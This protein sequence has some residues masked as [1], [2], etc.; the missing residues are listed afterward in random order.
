M[1]VE[2]WNQVPESTEPRYDPTR[3]V[4]S[5]QVQL[6]PGKEYVF[7]VNEE[8]HLGFRSEEGIPLAP[9]LVRFQTRPADKG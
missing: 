7:S 6:E 1:S 3:R 5:L 9:V 8:R 4:F 2:S